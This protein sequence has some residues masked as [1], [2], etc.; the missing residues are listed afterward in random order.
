MVLKV[1]V[2]S[3]GAEHWEQ[4]CRFVDVGCDSAEAQSRALC[5]FPRGGGSGGTLRVC[6]RYGFLCFT[7]SPNCRELMG[8]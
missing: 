1:A 4:G 5:G 2:V 6:G 8:G 7:N 3:P